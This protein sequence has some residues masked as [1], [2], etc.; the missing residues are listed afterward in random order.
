MDTYESVTVTLEINAQTQNVTATTVYD[1]KTISTTIPLSRTQHTATDSTTETF[2]FKIPST[3]SAS[4]IEVH[5]HSTFS[6]GRYGV[7]LTIDNHED[8]VGDVSL[9]TLGLEL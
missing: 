5:P 8:Y 7:C 9:E 2:T 3:T 6:G 1:S 4:A